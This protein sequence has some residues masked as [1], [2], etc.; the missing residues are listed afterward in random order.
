[1]AGLGGWVI[2]EGIPALSKKGETDPRES[3]DIQKFRVE[4][5]AGAI[6]TVPLIVQGEPTGVIVAINNTTQRDFT[7]KDVD[8]MTAMASQVSVALQNA[9]LFQSIAT[10]QRRLQA[11]LASSRDGVILLNWAG[12]ILVLNQ[13]AL[14]LMSAAGS[15]DEWVGRNLLDYLWQARHQT[16]DVVRATIEEMRRLQPDD[17][18]PHEGEFRVGNRV[19]RWLNLPATGAFSAPAADRSSGKPFGRLLVLRDVT[20]EHILEQM[21]EDLTHTMV[22]DLRNPLTNIHSALQFM[23]QYDRESL[24]SEQMEVLEISINSTERMT[25]LVNAI[26]DIN[27]LESGRMPLNRV[28]FSLEMS[29]LETWEMQRPQAEQKAIELSYDMPDEAALVYADVDLIERVLQNLLSNAV[30]FTPA[31]GAITVRAE[32]RVGAPGKAFITVQDSGA[33][34]PEEIRERVFKKFV[35]GS[36]EGRGSGLGLTFCKMVLEAHD[37]RIWLE[38]QTPGTGA[39]FTFTLPLAEADM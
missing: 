25:K 6:I 1:M 38:P 33:G 32:R 31:S 12:E 37:E 5:N 4:M 14:E 8:L 3:P 10:E 34:V 28:A 21:R 7:Q 39:T 15:P 18:R 22:H 30:K 35:T 13:A 29:L 2:R 20:E 17:T 26:L 23:T 36:Q 27:R 19:L 11:V 16:P 9:Q 24:S